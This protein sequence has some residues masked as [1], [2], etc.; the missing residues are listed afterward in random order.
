MIR[1][2][3]HNAEDIGQLARWVRARDLDEFR[4][5]ELPPIG[6]IVDEVAAGFL[7]LTDGNVGFLETF[8][9][10]P[11]APSE[12]RNIAILDIFTA[13]RERAIER[14]I[15][16]LFALTADDSIKK[17]AQLYGF[18]SLGMFELFEMDLNKTDLSKSK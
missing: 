14:G 18:S 13:L 3:L 1:P 6:F 9:T 17:R 12:K 15:H 11:Y 5:N 10:N 16:R 8:I 7:F 2:F 4:E